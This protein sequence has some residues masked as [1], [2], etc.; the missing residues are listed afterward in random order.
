MKNRSTCSW[1]PCSRRLPAQRR[2]TYRVRHQF[3]L[4]KI[5]IKLETMVNLSQW[6]ILSVESVSYAKS[7][8]LHDGFRVRWK[9]MRMVIGRGQQ[10]DCLLGSV[11]DSAPSSSPSLPPAM[12]CAALTQ[13]NSCKAETLLQ[14]LNF[15]WLIIHRFRGIITYVYWL[16][17][18][19]DL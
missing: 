10:R 16:G 4:T 8:W 2:L 1:R 14:W 6:N 19:D 15:Q 5:Q 18:R 11:T 17:T 13:A 12:M 7:I 9:Q 3:E